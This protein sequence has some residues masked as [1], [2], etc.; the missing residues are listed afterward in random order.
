MISKAME[1]YNEGKKVETA[2][3]NAQ[4]NEIINLIQENMKICNESR[5]FYRN[6]IYDDVR[7]KLENEGFSVKIVSNDGKPTYFIAVKDTHKAEPFP[8]EE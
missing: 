5:T 1:F 6:I 4:F 2:R 7:E 8:E 3:K